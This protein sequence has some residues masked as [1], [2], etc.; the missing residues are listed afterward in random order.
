MVYCRLSA[1]R[2]TA[3]VKCTHAQPQPSIMLVQ[4]ICISN[5]VRQVSEKLE[6][7]GLYCVILNC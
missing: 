2:D 4:K 3:K 7:L 1:R 6:S 5:H